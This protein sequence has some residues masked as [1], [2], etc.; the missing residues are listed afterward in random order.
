MFY[1]YGSS[2]TT[3]GGKVIKGGHKETYLIHHLRRECL[4]GL[5]EE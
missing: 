1:V 3:E 2:Y 5:D 4:E